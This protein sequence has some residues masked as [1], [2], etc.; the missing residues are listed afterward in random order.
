MDDG[1]GDVGGCTT[2]RRLARRRR[3]TRAPG[4]VLNPADAPA[5]VQSDAG[6]SL[7]GVSL[8]SSL[9]VSAGGVGSAAVSSVGSVETR[10]GSASV[11][12]G[13]RRDARGTSG[14]APTRGSARE[15]RGGP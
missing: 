12:A 4:G 10:R 7:A 3:P 5:A 2:A 13:F 1:K 15:A 14:A 11:A 6:V 9:G 8:S